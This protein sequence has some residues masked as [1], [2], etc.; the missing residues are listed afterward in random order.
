MITFNDKNLCC[1][2]NNNDIL[3]VDKISMYSLKYY[4]ILTDERK[5]ELQYESYAQRDGLR[6]KNVFKIRFNYK[7]FNAD[8]VKITKVDIVS[9]SIQIEFING[10][11]VKDYYDDVQKLIK[12]YKLLLDALQSGGGVI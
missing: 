7:M 10:L 12:D 11:V 1:I 6:L 2:M 4:L 8:V 3:Y 9:K 5:I